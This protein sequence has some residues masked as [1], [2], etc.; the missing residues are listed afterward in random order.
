MYN[1]SY[2]KEKER[3]R[4]LDLIQNYPFAFLTGSFNDGRQVAT[5]LPFLLEEREGELF[6][7][8]HL[9]R[10]TDHHKV[11]LENPN[12][13][14]VFT[15]P[16]A[17][18]SATLYSAKNVGSTWNY[19]SV[20]VSGDVR[21]MSDDELIQ[22]MKKLTLRFEGNNSQSPTFFDNLSQDYKSK[23]MPAIVGIELK[24][25]KIDNVFKLSQNKD[26]ESYRKIISELEKQGGDSAEIATEMKKRVDELF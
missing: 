17:Y 10:N 24:L 1:I 16:H 23:M 9:M 6:I 26:E 7:Q 12:V 3:N 5:Q 2:F 18:V 25:D 14:T 15:G 22:F 8:A 13:L 11:L 21:F 4:I 19:M 20:H